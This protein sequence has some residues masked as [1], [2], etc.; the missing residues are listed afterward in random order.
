[1]PTPVQISGLAIRSDSS[2]GPFR[3]SSGAFYF[4]AVGPASLALSYRF[5]IYKAT[6]PT[7]SW[8]SLTTL[9]STS[10]RTIIHIAG[11]QV[12]DEIHFCAAMFVSSTLTDVRYYVFDMSSETFTTSN[13]PIITDTNTGEYKQVS[14][15]VRSNGEKVAAIGGIATVMGVDRTKVRYSRKTTGNWSSAVVVDPAGAVN[16]GYPEVILGANDSVHFLFTGITVSLSYQ[17][18]LNSSNALQTVSSG[19]SALFPVA[20][21][22]V[23]S[24]VTKIVAAG[25]SFIGYFNS[26]NTPTINIGAGNNTSDTSG[27]YSRSEIFYIL[28]QVNNDFRLTSSTDFGAT[29]S[30]PITVYSGTSIRSNALNKDAT[31]YQSGD[32]FVIPYLFEDSNISYYNE[33]IVETIGPPPEPSGRRRFVIIC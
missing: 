26:G 30:T 5:I 20:G 31:I 24:G 27:V 11:Q 10:N 16:Y 12:G 21:S 8:S 28:Y 32:N 18:T 22:L 3:S 7:D 19:F 13:D 25:T 23:S 1:M 17:R 4:V 15:V 9:D 14:L 29:W 6:D 2:I 33:Y